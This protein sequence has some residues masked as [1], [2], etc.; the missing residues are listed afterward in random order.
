MIHIFRDVRTREEKKFRNMQGIYFPVYFQFGEEK[1]KSSKKQ[2]FFR[3]SESY[4]DLTPLSQASSILQCETMFPLSEDQMGRQ[5]K[6]GHHEELCQRAQV[7]V[8]FLTFHECPL[9]PKG[10]MDLAFIRL[11]L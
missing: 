7:L 6:M 3:S 5:A 11:L 1:A 10:R 4:S 9:H 2:K 8:I